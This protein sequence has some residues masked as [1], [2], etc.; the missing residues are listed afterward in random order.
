MLKLIDLIVLYIKAQLT[1]FLSV[2]PLNSQLSFKKE[3]I[4]STLSLIT[5]STLD[6][7]VEKFQQ[8]HDTIKTLKSDGFEFEQID[9]EYNEKI[10]E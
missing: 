7:Q 8:L 5:Q 1:L 9:K 6:F 10:Q 3:K 2:I 4:H